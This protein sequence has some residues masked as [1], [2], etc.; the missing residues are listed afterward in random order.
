MPQPLLLK[1]CHNFTPDFSR[2]ILK[3]FIKIEM[4]IF[5]QNITPIYFSKFIIL[6]QMIFN[7][8]LTISYFEVF[9][10]RS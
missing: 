10:L 1:A 5:Q 3:K 4:K 6:R 7:C 8:F 2:T 9:D